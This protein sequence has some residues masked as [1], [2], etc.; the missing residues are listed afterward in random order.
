MALFSRNP[1]P[2]SVE[3]RWRCSLRRST[4]SPLSLT[5]NRNEL[6]PRSIRASRTQRKSTEA[7]Q[8]SGG[9]SRLGLG[10]PGQTTEK[11]KSGATS[12][13]VPTCSVVIIACINSGSV[14]LAHWRPFGV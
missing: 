14:L 13:S 3:A 5:N 12:T 7:Q 6:L 9:W 1:A 4:S 11:V 10:K 8:R 2:L